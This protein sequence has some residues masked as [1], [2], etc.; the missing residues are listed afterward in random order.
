M[1]D[2]LDTDITMLLDRSGS[3]HTIHDDIV[4]G[5]DA[6]I[7]EQTAQPGRC[8]VSLFQFDDH[9]EQVYSGRPIHQVATLELEPRGRTALLDAIGRTILLTRQR[10]AGL[11]E[12][13]RPGDVILGIITDGQENASRE[14][15]RP[16]VR[17]LIDQAESVDG[18]VVL[19]L[20]ANQDAIEVGGSL[21]IPPSQSLTYAPTASR[22]GVGAFSASSLRYRT[23]RHHGGSHA[24]AKIE[25]GFTEDERRQAGS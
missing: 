9:V 24:E 15:T 16:V 20:G 5:F 10:L 11:A 4:G 3:M 2:P 22:P 21:G 18:W 1:S 17:E 13:Q 14:F 23:A 6:F 19:Y 8:T 25:A 12:D 7:V